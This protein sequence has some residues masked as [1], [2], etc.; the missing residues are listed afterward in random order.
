MATPGGEDMLLPSAPDPESILPRKNQGARMLKAIVMA[1]VIIAVANITGWL[2]G[3]QY[4]LYV[5]A[6]AVGALCMYA[7][8]K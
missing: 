2:L 6:V 5:Y 1:V 4:T 3:E 8:V 7:V